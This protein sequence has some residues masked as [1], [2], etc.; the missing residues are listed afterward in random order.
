MK[1]LKSKQHASF[2]GMFSM[3]LCI[4]AY[5]H[6][7]PLYTYSSVHTNIGV[8]CTF[9]HLCIQACM[10]SVHICVCA[11][12]HVCPLC[13]HVSM[14]TCMHVLV[15]WLICAYM[16]TCPLCTYASVHTGIH[17]LCALRHLCIHAYVWRSEDNS[18]CPVSDAFHSFFETGS[19]IGL[20]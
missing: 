7:Y 20:K 5:V 18:W 11:Y 10:F 3:H 19:L 13:T 4:C 8:F 14:H 2:C 17:V 15:H 9:M 16:H 6:A 1:L 12:K